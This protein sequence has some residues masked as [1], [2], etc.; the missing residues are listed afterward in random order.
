MPTDLIGIRPSLLDI[1]LSLIL[2]FPCIVNSASPPPPACMLSCINAVAR[3]IGLDHPSHITSICLQKD[4]IVGCLTDI[5]PFGNYN[6]ARDHFLH[7]CSKH[8]DAIR[9]HHAAHKGTMR[10]AI[11]KLTADDDPFDEKQVLSHIPSVTLSRSQQ[12]HVEAESQG[13]DNPKST[14]RSGGASLPSHTNLQ[15]PRPES[16]PEHNKIS[17]L[18]AFR[19]MID[20]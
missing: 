5:C 9:F 17:G 3:G 16:H 15:I 8:G 7:A 10:W 2:S 12:T 20:E 4:A 13:L 19:M 14:E 6:T 1:V 11:E 18:E